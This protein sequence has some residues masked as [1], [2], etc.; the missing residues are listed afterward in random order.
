MKRY[1]FCLSFALTLFLC[2]CNSNTVIIY[3][4]KLCF[5]FDKGYNG[6]ISIVGE[7]QSI[8]YDEYSFS[9][10]HYYFSMYLFPK[11][12]DNGFIKYFEY[13]IHY[14]S[15]AGTQLLSEVY[16][17]WQTSF[18]TY[19]LEKE[20]LSLIY[21]EPTEKGTVFTNNLFD[22]PAYVA[23][24]NFDSE[25]CYAI[26][27]DESYTIAYIYFFDIKSIDNLVFDSKYKPK[28]L[29]SESDFSGYYLKEFYSAYAFYGN[30]GE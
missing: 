26:L 12:I 23:I 4:P 5:T 18:E 20:R 17:E 29:L 2:C 22:L 15:D 3:E 30:K 7:P 14:N 27:D 1:N 28:K 16:V 8:T 24:Y 9:I 13:L 6:E 21:Y 10:V 25:F 19:K 11:H